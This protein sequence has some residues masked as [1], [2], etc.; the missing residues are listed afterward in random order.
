[1]KWAALRPAGLWLFI[2]CLEFATTRKHINW[3]GSSTWVDEFQATLEFPLFLYICAECRDIL[4]VWDSLQL[5]KSSPVSYTGR[6]PSNTGRLWSIPTAV[7]LSPVN[8]QCIKTGAAG[9]RS[10]L[11]DTALPGT[12][13][14]TLQALDDTE[15]KE[16]CGIKRDVQGHQLYP[17]NI[18]GSVPYKPA[19]T[20]LK[21]KLFPCLIWLGKNSRINSL[22]S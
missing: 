9:W 2:E 5:K 7:A 3:K 19:H 15:M 4:S 22:N 8:W 17:S 18:R 21:T 10:D 12:L 13:Y 14:R 20:C 6:K 1:M 16:K 11:C